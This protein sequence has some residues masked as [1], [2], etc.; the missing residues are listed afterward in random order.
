MI[1]RILL[2]LTQKDLER[3]MRILGKSSVYNY[4]NLNYALSRGNAEMFSNFF[5]NRINNINEKEAI[6]KFLHTKESMYSYRKGALNN[7]KNTPPNEQ[8]KRLI[9]I[10]RKNQISSIIKIH[11]NINTDKGIVNVDLFIENKK[12]P[13]IIEAT[14]FYEIKSKKFSN[15]WKQKIFLLDYRFAKIKRKFPNSLTYIA[16]EIDNN[17]QI[18][19]RIKKF[20]KEQTIAV[21]DIFINKDFERLNK[22]IKGAIK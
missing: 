20:V 9:N 17:A 8:E 11:E 5:N 16:L 12:K 14:R 3:E 22:T 6:N 19:Y 15:N 21:D 13:V 1:F 2:G 7:L 4:E 10:L 18:E